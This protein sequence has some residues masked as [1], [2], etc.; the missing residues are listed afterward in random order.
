MV[1]KIGD[2]LKRRLVLV[3]S[4]MR[5]RDMNLQIMELFKSSSPK[6]ISTGSLIKVQYYNNMPK[7][8]DVSLNRLQS[9]MGILLQV[10]HHTLEPTFTVRSVIDGVGVEQVF[11]INSPLIKNVEVLWA[12]QQKCT[13][14]LLELR[15][16]PYKI[17]TMIND[18]KVKI[19]NQ[20]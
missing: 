2:E 9:Y 12:P 8:S 1:V 19:K 15:E 13:K 16:R 3:K 7:S 11:C 20:T 10:K 5:A 17:A 6:A 4:M 18:Y 14:P